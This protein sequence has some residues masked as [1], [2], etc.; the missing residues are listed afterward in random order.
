MTNVLMTSNGQWALVQCSMCHEVNKYPAATAT[1]APIRCDCGNEMDV[2][3]ALMANAADQMLRI[4]RTGS[5]QG[6]DV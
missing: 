1:L 2:A 3:T 4:T 5:I 6:E